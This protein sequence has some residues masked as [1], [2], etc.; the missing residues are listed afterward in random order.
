MRQDL[1]KAS[2]LWHKKNHDSKLVSTQTSLVFL[3]S[4]QEE[5]NNSIIE[6]NTTINT[7]SRNKKL[8]DISEDTLTVAQIEI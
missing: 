2:P 3:K 8:I 6:Y 1:D 7:S 5:L 4:A